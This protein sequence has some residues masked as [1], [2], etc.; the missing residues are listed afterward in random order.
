MD[1][2]FVSELLESINLAKAGFTGYLPD[3]KPTE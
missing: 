1:F 2:I 3:L